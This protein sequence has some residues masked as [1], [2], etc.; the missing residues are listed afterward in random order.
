MMSNDYNFTIYQQTSGMVLGFHGCDRAVAMDILNS[1]NKHLN[2]SKEP[3]DWLGS[4]IYFW[5]NDPLRAYEWACQMKIR[6]P[7]KVKDPF[8]I[9]AIIDLG[10]CL[11]FCERQSILLLQKA[12]NDLK[13]AWEQMGM[14]LK[15]NVIPDEGGF[16]LKRYLDCIVIN[17][18]HDIVKSDNINFDTVYGYFQEGADAYEGAGI[19]EKSHIQVCVRN[20]KC[21]KGYFLPRED[22]SPL[23]FKSVTIVQK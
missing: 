20:N 3:Y 18:I 9:G 23:K 10:M 13:D 2:P 1:R 6:H 22:R 8:V 14:S 19:K 11:N 4:G 5:L 16:A 7:D 12:Y 17:R 21:I 15:K